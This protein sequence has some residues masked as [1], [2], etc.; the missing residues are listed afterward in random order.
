MRAGQSPT[1]LP[2]DTNTTTPNETSTA[3]TTLPAWAAATEA[4][5]R[6]PQRRQSTERRM[7]PPSSGA[8][9]MRLKTASKRLICHSQASKAVA[10]PWMPAATASAWAA[11]KSAASPMLVAG[12]TAAI[13]KSAS[14]VWAS[15]SSWAMP[16]KT[17]S[18]MERTRTPL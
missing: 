2:V 4:R 11:P 9:G 18:V 10:S 7:R 6:S 12:P 3:A 16:P 13:R 1:G 5:V 15:P 17:N 14:G 8:P